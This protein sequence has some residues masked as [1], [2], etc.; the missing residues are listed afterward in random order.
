[1]SLGAQL[2]LA[3]GLVVAA[4]GAVV[5]VTG[6]GRARV[7]V[8]AVLA[9]VSLG[10]LALGVARDDVL[11]PGTLP[12]E[13]RPLEER[14]DDY[15]RSDA[16]RS[17][18][19]VEYDSWHHSF[20]RSMTTVAT[21][22]NVVA[23]FSDQLLRYDG[24]EWR[25]SRRGDEYFATSVRPGESP[26][27]SILEESRITMI[28]GS[29]H[30]QVFW[31]ETGAARKIV[32]F[33][34]CWRIDE[35]RWI[36]IDA[37]F[38][39]P[40]GT[41][42]A[43][44]EGRWNKGCAKCHTTGL[45]PGLTD[46]HAMDT[47][48]AEFG[49]ACEACHG[50]GGEHVAANHQPARRF[51]HHLSDAVDDTIVNPASLSPERG[52]EV[53]AQCHAV[54]MLPDRRAEL[55]WA[56]R[57]FRFRPGDDLLATRELER[58]GENWFWPDGMIR[59]SGREYNG[60]SASPCFT[61]EDDAQR[62]ACTDCHV[63]HRRPDDPRPF[64]EW[65]EDQ[66]G[67]GMDGNAACTQ[68]HDEYADAVELAAHT[69]HPVVPGEPGEPGDAGDAGATRGSR[70]YD[71][72]MPHTTYG[73]LKAIRSHEV[74]SPSVRESTEHGRPNACNLCHLDRTLEW[75]ADELAAGWG[76]PAPGT[77]EGG[78]ELTRDE[79]EVSAAVLW[80]L[81][82]D[83]GQRALLAWHAGWAPAHEASGD[84]WLA[85][86]LAPLLD[87]P[88]A[89]VRFVA[90]RALRELP[91]FADWDGDYLDAPVRRRYAV[92]K[93]REAWSR[94][95]AVADR[96]AVLVRPDGSLDEETW[97]RLVAGR[98]DRPVSLHE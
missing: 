75:A 84:E 42:Q 43:T 16:C 8:S 11:R 20:H 27:A 90:H 83:A 50:P 70:C 79:R 49:I 65:R 12:P 45:Q 37:A 55:D 18:H 7:V 14:H 94:R 52:S 34:M 67:P 82:G 59:V 24:K 91:G 39:F 35:Q 26:A 86:I 74:S 32:L 41:R 38:L 19:P 76:V 10:A 96:A 73:L 71:C 72:H 97:S 85:P 64:E 68:C 15:V 53:C 56:L 92:V 77:P 22:A 62:M 31:L 88:Y 40:P 9:V 29:H 4:L 54:T 30:F 69:R 58:E 63:L 80:L 78:R 81:S 61:H 25:L 17:C 2:C 51:R 36:P 6:T 48:A 28:T 98:D 57:G 66:L 60:L 33:P 47:R 1:M 3:A 44:G 23:D 93:A 5:A 89:A 13:G 87:D 95:R 21:P 46:P